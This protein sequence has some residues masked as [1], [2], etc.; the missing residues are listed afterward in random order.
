M[1]KFDKRIAIRIP[2]EQRA[3]INNL[4]KNGHYENLSQFL[5]TAIQEFLTQAERR[6]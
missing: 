1:K 5:R 6:E 3:K 2:S 4:I